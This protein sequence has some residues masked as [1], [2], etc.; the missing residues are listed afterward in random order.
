MLQES[1][2]RALRGRVKE[3]E[4]AAADVTESYLSLPGSVDSQPIL[5]HF[6]RELANFPDGHKG[7]WVEAS[8]AA[9]LEAGVSFVRFEESGHVV[10]EER[11]A[12][13]A[14]A[15]LLVDLRQCGPAFPAARWRQ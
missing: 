13:W 11:Q 1:D 5:E 9:F 10:L 12:Q 15:G 6:V 7:A 8:M 3:L 4:P 14:T 2:A